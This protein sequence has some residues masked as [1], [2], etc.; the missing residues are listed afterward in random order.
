M[1]KNF[2]FTPLGINYREV[3]YFDSIG[4]RKI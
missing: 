4:I 1:K 3:F 2:L